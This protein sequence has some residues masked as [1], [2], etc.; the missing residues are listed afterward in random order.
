MAHSLT[1]LCGLGLFSDALPDGLRYTLCVA[2]S[3]IGGVIPAAVMSSSA[4]LAR[5]PRQVSALQGLI[6]QGSQLGQFIGT[7]LIAAVVA[8]SGSWGAAA[9]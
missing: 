5:S 3:F 2:L 1:G 9:G 8:T 6:M 4:V 7:P